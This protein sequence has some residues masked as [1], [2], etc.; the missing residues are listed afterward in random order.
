MSVYGT[1]TPPST[2]RS[3]SRHPGC[4]DLSPLRA[5]RRIPICAARIFLCGNPDSSD[6][7][8]HSS[9]SRRLMRP[10]I[11]PARWC[12]NVDLLS[13][14]Y[15]FRPHLRSRLTLG[16]R[17]FPRKPSSYGGGDSR[18]TYR[19]S[20]RHPHFPCLQHPFRYAFT[21]PGNAPLP[22]PGDEP[23]RNPQLRCIA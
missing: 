14:G 21:D 8:S 23:L 6:G 17:P 12:R 19:Y 11:A 7:H 15:A 5:S 2:L 16:G 3:F 13:I 9:A 22:L 4:G 1:G 10:S 20:C 18:P